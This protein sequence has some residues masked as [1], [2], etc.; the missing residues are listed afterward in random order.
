[1]RGEGNFH[2]PNEWKSECKKHEVKIQIWGGEGEN[3]TEE[4]GR[5]LR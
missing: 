4:L 2:P 3:A 5:K 1:V